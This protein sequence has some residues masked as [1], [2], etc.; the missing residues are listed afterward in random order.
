MTFTCILLNKV[1]IGND[2]LGLYGIFFTHTKFLN[3]LF[4]LVVLLNIPESKPNI[5]SILKD[6]GSIANV[7]RLKRYVTLESLIIN[8]D[9]S[10]EI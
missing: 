5:I 4:N 8:Q 6:V 3:K 2:I 9:R 7:L 1:I 10:T